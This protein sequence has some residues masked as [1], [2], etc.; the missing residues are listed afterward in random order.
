MFKDISTCLFS[1][2]GVEKGHEK[3]IL[4]VHIPGRMVR[5]A[6]GLIVAK[7]HDTLHTAV[8]QKRIL[9]KA[10]LQVSRNGL[11]PL[12]ESCQSGINHWYEFY[13]SVCIHSIQ[14]I[15]KNFQ[16]IHI[17]SGHVHQMQGNQQLFKFVLL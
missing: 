3:E 17:R 6:C 12:F 9:H 16:E 1:H 13:S 2:V 7:F 15:I 5:E 10:E 11:M 14:I 8:R 4:D